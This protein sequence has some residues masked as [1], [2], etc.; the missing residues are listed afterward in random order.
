[1]RKAFTLPEL[2]IAVTISAILMTG[3]LAFVGSGIGNA[4]KL[5]KEATLSTANTPFDDALGEII[6]ASP[7]KVSHTGVYSGE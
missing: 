3:I 2:L 5:K 4:W 1:M 6:G 7:A